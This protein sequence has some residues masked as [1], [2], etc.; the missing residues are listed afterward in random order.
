MMA[1]GYLDP[2]KGPTVNG[3]RLE[4]LTVQTS[5]YGAVIPRLYGTITVNGNVIWLENNQ[6]R[7]TVTK[8]KSGGK[9][10]GSKTTTK[11]YTYSAT[12]AVGLVD[13]RSTGGPI[14]GVRRIWIGADLYY[15]A[16]S[17][18]FETIAASND[19]A[20]GFAVYDG[21]DTQAP[22][23][24]IQADI[25]IAPA[26]RGVA[27]LVFYDLP[28]E[29]YGNSLMGAQ[30]RAEIVANGTPD[31][32]PYTIRTMPNQVNYGRTAW[33][34]AIYCS[35]G[36]AT[37]KCHTS[38]DGI[39]WTEHD[40]GATYTCWSLIAVGNVFYA[41][42]S[43]Y[44]LRSEDGIAWTQVTPYRPH[45][46]TA[47]AWSGSKFLVAADSQPW[48]S[49]TDGITWVQQTAPGTVLGLGAGSYGRTLAWNGSVFVTMT[50]FGG[51]R[52]LTS[53]DGDSWTHTFTAG[54]GGWEEIAVL[55]TRFC[56]TS[57]G[58]YLV[59]VSDDGVV[60]D[61]YAMPSNHVNS[62]CA[63]DGLFFCTDQGQ[64]HIS[65]DGIN[66]D[67]YSF[68]YAGV[69]YGGAAWNGAWFAVTSPSPSARALTVKPRDLDINTVT[70]GSIV[71]SESLQSGLLT[72]GDID[73]SALTQAVRGYRVSTCLLYTSPSPRD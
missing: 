56:L 1:G 52:I 4:D 32:W 23:P 35:F 29:R 2:P 48:L 21:S 7:E 44:I 64:Y 61:M 18:D 31:I 16:G 22:D 30:V 20:T 6:L 42:C 8:T 66:W 24:R 25:S 62:I 34:G 50:K 46:Y 58:Q 10:G 71:S 59:L 27:Y 39:T 49:S 14:T 36:S 55:G 43:F 38:P 11:T 40:L 69:T 19:V 57:N 65:A 68:P 41:A 26:W 15:D 72:A 28:L 53:P 33:N 54:G 45:Y 60:W 37:T 73:V 63:G 17:D 5:T 3:P 13:T 12:F 51:L 9:G 67:S 47:I 70:L